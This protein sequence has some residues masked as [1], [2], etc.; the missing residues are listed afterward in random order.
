MVSYY[1]CLRKTL[2]WHKKFALH[3]FDVYVQNAH[4]LLRKQDRNSKM[5]LL[6]F[7][8]EFTTHLLGMSDIDTKSATPR[9]ST[10]SQSNLPENRMSPFS[11]DN[12]HCLEKL[13]PT[14]KKKIPGKP[15]RVCTKEKN[16]QK[17]LIFA[18]YAQKSQP[19]AY[20]N[21]SKYITQIP[22]LCLHNLL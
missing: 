19:Y 7:R 13:P 11:E 14:E 22:D 8:E 16:A 20:S 10:S 3:I 2:R 12:F 1:S 4:R 15:C 18:L 6:K 21:V 5:R 17:A 9:A